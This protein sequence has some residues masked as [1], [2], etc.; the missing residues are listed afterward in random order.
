MMD[1]LIPLPVAIPLVAA[2]IFA[3]TTHFIPRRLADLLAL[4]TTAA[5]AW[6]C[7][8]LLLGS[9][10]GTLVHWM[11][12][13]L[14]RGDVAL[15]IA[16][17]IDPM[18]AGFALTVAVLTFA[19]LLFSWG[20]LESDGAMFHGLMMVFLG[21]MVGFAYSGDIF[22]QF[23]FFELM[24][25]ASY[26]LTAYKL[27]ESSLEGG[28]NYAVVTSIG[29]FLL[30]IGISLV[31]G[32]TGALNLAQLGQSLA[33]GPRD[34]LVIVGLVSIVAGYL[35]KAAIVPFHFWISDAHAVAPTPACV[36]F[37]GA[38]VPLG[39]YGVGRIYWS[40]FEPSMHSQADTL[41]AMLLALGALSAVLSAAVCFLQRHLKRLLAFSTASHMGVALIG[42]A[43]LDGKAAGGMGQYLLAHGLIKAALFLCAGML[44]HALEDV[45]EMSL[46]GR[47]RRLRAAM[48][49]YFVGAIGLAGIPGFGMFDG[50]S[51]IEDAA[52]S[53]GQAWVPWVLL[54]ASGVTSA[55]MLRAGCR[56]FFGWGLREGGE[57]A[58]PTEKEHPETHGE[59]LK[60][61]GS[62]VLATGL[63][64]AVALGVGLWPRSKPTAE[65]AGARFSDT[66]V[67]QAAVM[68]DRTQPIGIPA[69]EPPKPEALLYS[70]GGLAL[71][72]GL[73]GY[74]LW[75][76]RRDRPGVLS[77]G[78]NAL[79]S[80][81]VGDYVA[82][83]AAGVAGMGCY[84]LLTTR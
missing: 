84:L 69:P 51:L 78:L 70:G 43:L 36:L 5:V 16:F 65:A 57:H 81:H 83:L 11:G 39:L 7:W 38:M 66:A 30:L 72:L 26:A 29:A 17:T 61:P 75:G 4:I 77:R 73:A 14:P 27:E 28:L 20:Y 52:K 64:L 47:A 68:H 10:H 46:F 34:A 3:A 31:Y 63:L 15:G 40:A 9:Y 58:G 41:R 33:S 67:F 48:V 50:K 18:A 76:P 23:V 79:H 56:I 49:L 54:V 59:R 6:I 45:D 71:A 8:Q 24:G 60:T 13:W 25:V 74:A 21:A 35:I 82:W 22:T 37:S 42:L 53:A 2:A 1:R 62:M 19:A 44:L 32:R 80:G 12:G 55:A